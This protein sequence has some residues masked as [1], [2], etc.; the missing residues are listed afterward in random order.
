LKSSKKTLI[1]LE[2]ID[3]NII[4]LGWVS[5]FTDMASAMVTTLLPVFVVYVLNEG[6]DKL[7]FIIAIATFISYA[8]RIV[9]G[10]LS[11]K[12]Q[13]VK[14]FVVTG[15]LI[16]A[17]TKPLLMFSNSFTSVALFRTLERTGK[18]V[19]SASKDS[20][21]SK[22]SQ[23]NQA[24]KTFGFHKMMDI[25]GEMIG[26]LIIAGVF[27]FSTQ[28]EELIRDIFGWTLLPGL[29]ATAIVLFFVKEVP[30]KTPKKTAVINREDYKLFWIL[31]SYFLFLL[32]LMSD[33]YFIV[34]AKASGMTL[35]Q[36]PLLVITSTLTQTLVSYYSGIL[37]DRLGVNIMLFISYLFGTVSLFF[38]SQHYLWLAFIF[39]G[40]FTVTSLNT[41]RTYISDNAKSIGFIYGIFYAGIAVFSAIGAIAI[42]QIWKYYGFESTI[43]FSMTGCIFVTILIFLNS[44]IKH[45]N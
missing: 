4:Y 27:Y 29:I 24:G 40:L 44:I 14:P 33:Q 22:Y 1:T 38:L 8:L 43:I 26:S 18:A 23:K 5:F 3:K 12:Y 7:G 16:S 6:V 34:E 21:I 9:F 41:I 28:N 32:F 25:S 20:L 11:D 10:Y 36:I 42:G 13:I 45:G 19:R 2:K 39:L 37:I 35:E 15:Y 30:K 17:I 31:G